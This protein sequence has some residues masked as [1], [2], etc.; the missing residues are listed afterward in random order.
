MAENAFSFAPGARSREVGRATIGII[1]CKDR[2]EV[3]VEY[4]LR[5]SGKPMG[6]AKYPPSTALPEQLR[7][8]LPT[9]EELSAVTGDGGEFEF[10]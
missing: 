9:A 6:V 10:R 3:I 4:A 7:N 8:E 1:L 5:D 2:N